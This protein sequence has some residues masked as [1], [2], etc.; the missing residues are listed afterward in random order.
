MA[1][2]P[3]RPSLDASDIL[4]IAERVAELVLAKLGHG[5]PPAPANDAPRPPDA[6]PELTDDE[7]RELGLERVARRA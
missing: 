1:D 3:Q 6:E 5:L 4:L 2:D 7:L